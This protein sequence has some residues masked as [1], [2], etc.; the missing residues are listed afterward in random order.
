[1]GEGQAE[2]L[3]SDLEP[4]LELWSLAFSVA[5]VLGAGVAPAL[6]GAFVGSGSLIGTMDGVAAVA[7]QF[8]ALLTFFLLVGAAISCLRKAR[9]LW[10]SLSLAALAAPI[11]VMLSSAQR[12]ELGE[13][14]HFATLLAAGLAL[15]LASLLVGARS[16]PGLALVLASVVLLSDVA[17]LALELTA[18]PLVLHAALLALRTGAAAAATLLVLVQLAW[19]AGAAR[20]A[21]PLLLGGAMLAALAVDPRLPASAPTWQVVAGRALTQLT[22]LELGPVP[23]RLSAALLALALGATA[24]ALLARVLRRRQV[25]LG[26]VLS[27]SAALAATSRPSPLVLGALTLLALAH[28]A[29]RAPRLAR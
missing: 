9:P 22:P 21:L 20:F 28:A 2:F 5:L 8:A 26:V 23:G 1:M 11:A 25:E 15:P 6:R 19:V 4:L 3:G 7:S 27:A 17:R 24:W 13:A 14:A 29:L 18:P 12:I 10:L 16:V